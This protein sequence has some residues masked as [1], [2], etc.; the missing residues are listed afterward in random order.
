VANAN[1]RIISGTHYSL[2]QVVYITGVTSLGGGS[3]TVTISPGVYSTN[4]RSGQ[5]PGAWWP[6]FAQNEGIENLTLDGTSD[7]DGTLAMFSCYQ[8]WA[9]KHTVYRWRKE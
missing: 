5:N 1:G 7:P 9:K 4:V 6:G 2:Q 8:C 3:Y